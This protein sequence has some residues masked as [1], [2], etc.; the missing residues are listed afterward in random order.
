VDI[1]DLAPNLQKVPGRLVYAGAVTYD[2]NLEAVRWFCRY[3]LPLVQCN[4]PGVELH[5]TGST[6]GVDLGD[7]HHVP[8]LVFTGYL[9]DV[10]SYVEESEIAVV[11][12]LTGGG[13]R[14]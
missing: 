3:V 12:L 2:A 11:P 10:A 8:G 7:L 9:P 4:D 6:A 14:L 1:V 13:T 5:V